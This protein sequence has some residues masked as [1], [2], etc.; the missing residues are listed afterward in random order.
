MPE[1]YPPFT[2]QTARQKV[3]AAQDAWNTCDPE[4]VAKVYTEDSEWRNRG[5]FIKGHEQ[6]KDFLARKWSKELDY[7]LRKDLWAFQENKI[8]VSYEYES[9]DPGGQWWRS[10]GIELWEFAEDGRM[11]RRQASINDLPIEQS[12][13]RVGV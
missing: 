2:E 4:V 1:P 6:I 10:H 5:E 9:H 11:C 7:H 12:E 3:K 13:R 8:A